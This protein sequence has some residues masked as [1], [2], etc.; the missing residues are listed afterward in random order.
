MTFVVQVGLTTGAGVSS[1]YL[2]LDDPVAGLLDVQV[3]A[4][5]DVYT[6]LSVDSNGQQRVMTLD[7]D[8]SSTQGAGMLVEYAAGTLSMTLRDDDGDLDPSNIA[9]PIPGVWI[10]VAKIYGGN[11][12]PLFSGTIDSW[13]PEHRYPDQAVVVITATDLLASFAGYD[14]GAVT[15]TGAGATSGARINAIL[16]SVSWPAGARNIDTGSVTVAATDFSGNA[17]D[18]MRNV[19]VAEVGDLWATADGKIRFRSRYNLYTA[20]ASRTV[21]ATFGS[22]PTLGELPWVGQLGLSYDR[23]RL[24]NVVRASRPSGTVTEVGDEVS[25]NRYRD[26]AEEQLDL[27]LNDDSQVETWATYVLARDSTPKLRFTDVEIDPR[28]NESA[29]YPQVLTRDFGDRIAV[30]RRPPGV[31]ADTRECYIRGVH[32]SFQAPTA[33][34]T[35]WELEP[36][37]IGNPFI[38]D[39]P[40]YGLLD[41]T[42]VLIL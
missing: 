39:D 18:E 17:L 27:V 14:R 1:T 36:A 22:N 34:Q 23:S 32:H 37:V 35:R 26:K 40:T 42:N 19:A 15:P 29:L 6:D 10:N 38:L 3:L 25:R 9:E 5:P 28:A 11:V 31:S 4:P 33:W 7:I 12:Y 41:S 16:D 2:R 21:Q 24:I 30:V 13:L 8:R 20:V